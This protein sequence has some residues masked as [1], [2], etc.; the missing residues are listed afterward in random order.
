MGLEAGAGVVAV[1]GHGKGGKGQQVDAVSV[2]QSGHV[3]IAERQAEHRGYAAVVACS[4]SHPQAVVIAPLHIKVLPVKQ[5]VHDDVCPGA[6]V[7]DVAQDV[8]LV[9]AERMDDLANGHNEIGALPR[10]HNALDDASEIGILVFVE[11]IFV[12]E[13]LYDVGILGGQCLAHLGAGVLA[14]DAAAHLYQAEQRAAVPCRKVGLL[15][16]HYLH[17]LLRIVDERTQVTDFVC[18]ESFAEQFV[19][20]AADVAAGIAQDMKKSLMLAMNVGHKVFRT[21]G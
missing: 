4:S 16:L 21:L 10:V 15:S 11:G 8:E 2:L 6:A 20:L 14:G 9:D 18:C 3:A 12:K 1:G 17:L 19:H 13:F 7:V 5:I